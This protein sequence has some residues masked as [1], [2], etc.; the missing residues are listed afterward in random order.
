M[1]QQVTQWHT[2]L[3]IGQQV[4]W[5]DPNHGVNSGVFRVDDILADNG[6]VTGNDSV[7]VLNSGSGSV[8]NACMADLESIERATARL[9]R[10][11]ARMDDVVAAANE[12]MA[13]VTIGKELD[14]GLWI[15]IESHEGY[16]QLN[17]ALA[18]YKAGSGQDPTGR[19]VYAGY[20]CMNGATVKVDFDVPAGSSAMRTDAAMLAALAQQA[21]IN[22]LS[23]G[24]VDVTDLDDED[25]IA[26]R[27]RRA[28]RDR[29]IRTEL[30]DALVSARVDVG[31]LR[32]YSDADLDNAQ[33]MGTDGWLMPDG[34]E[35]WLVKRASHASTDLHYQQRL[36]TLK[37][38]IGHFSAQVVAYGGRSC[39]QDKRRAT[40]SRRCLMKRL[41]ALAR[42]T[43]S[44]P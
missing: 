36:A 4:F 14:D 31:V 8:F 33:P 28:Q 15:K 40:T 44:T 19:T 21:E 7:V 10:E 9:Q 41:S 1:N 29:C 32:L 23:I 25:E 11:V 26:K 13:G 39:P 22:Y 17:A 37:R 16:R 34:L 38:E 18:S 20:C 24:Q 27:E 12:L 2:S 3:A 35:L 6:E 30:L 5:N 42:L 43:D